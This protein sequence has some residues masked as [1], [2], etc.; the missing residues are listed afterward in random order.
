MIRSAANGA[1]KTSELL[2]KKDG[3]NKRALARIS[4]EM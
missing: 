3:I 1:K 4:A 2:F